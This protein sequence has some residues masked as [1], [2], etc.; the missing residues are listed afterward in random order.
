MNKKVGNTLEGFKKQDISVGNSK[1]KNNPV[2]KEKA[3]EILKHLA[4]GIDPFKKEEL[5]PDSFIHDVKVVRALIF[6]IESLRNF[7]KKEQSKKIEIIKE[8]NADGKLED[9]LF[10]TLRKWRLK[11]CRE[12]GVPAYVVIP[13]ETLREIAREKPI[14]IELLKGIYGMGKRRIENYG[15]ILCE[16]VIEEL[17]RKRTN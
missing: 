7:E 9:E 15:E 5:D 12:L 10:E 11:K 3:I 17:E 1:K 8:E 13:N 6:A 4:F 16:I 2:D 14:K